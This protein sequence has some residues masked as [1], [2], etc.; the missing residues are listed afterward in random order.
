[1]VNDKHEL[2]VLAISEELSK[3]LYDY[4]T[5]EGE[6]ALDL[7]MRNWLYREI[8]NKVGAV[9]DKGGV[10]VVLCWSP[11]RFGMRRLLV[12]TGL[13]EF[14]CISDEEL[15]NATRKINCTIEVV[16][17]LGKDFVVPLETHSQSDGSKTKSNE[18]V[19][20]KS[21]GLSKED[22]AKLQ[23]GLESILANL[24]EFEQKVISMRF[25]LEGEQSH[26]LEE[27][28]NAFD[29]SREQIRMIEAKALRLLRKNVSSDE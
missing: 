2:Y 22:Y 16:D 13:A 4:I 12:G 8:T 15:V 3:Y 10:P 18:V 19:Q 6:I 25:G 29:I 7:V 17:T 11:I 21:K 20:E 14:Y 5:E 9:T 24:D 1:M 26:T 27:V 23:K 28:G